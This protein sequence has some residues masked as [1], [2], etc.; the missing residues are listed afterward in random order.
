MELFSKVLLAMFFAMGAVVL[1]R[2]HISVR[3]GALLGDG[4]TL[5]NHGNHDARTAT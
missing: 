4:D 3:F 2:A 1:F 5:V